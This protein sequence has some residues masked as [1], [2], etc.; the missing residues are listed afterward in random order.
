V[1]VAEF[2]EYEILRLGPEGQNFSLSRI[3]A[4]VAVHFSLQHAVVSA[5][6]HAVVNDW[7]TN[8]LWNEDRPYILVRI[9]SITIA[10]FP[11][12]CPFA[13]EEDGGVEQGEW[14]DAL[15]VKYEMQLEKVK[16]RING[17]M[18]IAQFSF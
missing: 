14:T 11:I 2:S 17:V 18:T 8:A 16:H 4:A 7:W 9:G 5:V 10:R 3:G 6:A 13:E 15:E 1:K 12:F